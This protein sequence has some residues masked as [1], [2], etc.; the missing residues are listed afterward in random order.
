MGVARTE[1]VLAVSCLTKHAELSPL[2][3]W[4][5][6]RGVKTKSGEVVELKT[7]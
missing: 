6:G 1:Y 2:E 5:M 4:E 7:R 3:I